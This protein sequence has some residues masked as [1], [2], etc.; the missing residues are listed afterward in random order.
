[1]KFSVKPTFN[2]SHLLPVLVLCLCLAVTYYLWSLAYQFSKQELQQQFDFR[3]NEIEILIKQR[4]RAYAEVLHGGRGLFIASDTVSRDE[5][6]VYINELDIEK[7]YPGI[8]GVGFSI[9]IPAG[10]KQQHLAAIRSEGFSDYNI[11]PEGVRELYSAI[12]YIE[13]FSDRNLRAFGFDMYSETVRRTAMDRAWRNNE[14]AFSG[15][16]TLVQESGKNVQAGF[17][18]YLPVYR[19][20]AD[21]S[22]LARRLANFRGW[23]YAP[24]RMDDFM[25][26]VLEK[27]SK[28]N[29]DVD[30]DIYDG[31]QPL[32]QALLYNRNNDS[33]TESQSVFSTRKQIAIAGNSWLLHIHSHA[34]F[35]KQ[36]DLRQAYLTA[37]V[38]IVIT[39]MLTTITWLLANS[40]RR[41]FALA[42]KIS[43]DLI[44]RE[45][46]YQQMFE[47]SSSIAVLIDLK[48]GNIIDAN[49][50]ASS[51]W[52]YSIEK[53][54]TMN[55]GEIDTR[56]ITEVLPLFELILSKSQ[57]V[58]AQHRL[59]DGQIKEVEIYANAIVYQGQMVIHS[60]VHDITT[61]KQQEE[62]IRRLSDSA[63]NKAKLEA[64]KANRVKSEFLANMSHEI[65]TPMNAITG[66][67]HLAL[68]TELTAKQRNYLNK[69]SYA[70]HSLLSIINDILDFSKIESG[71]LE[72]ET[73]PFS[74]DEVLRYIADIVEMNAKQKNIVV[75][76]LVNEG[77]PRWL[78]GDTLRLSQILINLASNAVKFTEQ[79]KI[80]ISVKPELRDAEAVVL[81]F[82][83]Q[84]S[85]IGMTST[86]IE[87]LFQPFSQADSSITRRYGGTGL[88]LTISKQL[89]EMMGGK[90]RVESEPGKGSTFIF[91]I[92]LGIAQKP[93]AS[94]KTG[95]SQQNTVEDFSC[96]TGR[97]IL[98][99]EDN[100][101]NRELATELLTNLGV[102][103][104]IAENGREAVKR[105]FKEPFDLV[106]MD[107]QM[108]EMDGLTA[109]RLI[110]ADVRF[111]RLPIIAMTANAMTGDRKNSLEAGMND[112]ISKPIMPEKLAAVLKFWL[113]NAIPEKLLKNPVPAQKTQQP[114][115]QLNS[116]IQLPDYLPSFNIAVA[117][118]RAAD[119]P[120]LLRK[121]LFMFNDEY[122]NLMP[123][124][125][126]YLQAGDYEEIRQKAHSLKGAAASLEATE[127]VA[128]AAALEK[129]CFNKEI[130]AIKVLVDELDKAL[131]A[132][133][134][135]IRSLKN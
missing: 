108:P 107:I 49:P 51:F 39:L 58:Y 99:V 13:P 18:M 79:G 6:K 89:V 10:K 62:E 105:V 97:K 71:R 112:H 57:H 122:Q 55:I 78:I 84:D 68:K 38:G 114:P 126:K 87:K 61:R 98:L 24:F 17:L 94:H 9:L 67:L 25:Q 48:N 50:A 12:I 91:T 109:T 115:P 36:I 106:F 14:I 86:Q 29:P 113:T 131:T 90:I 133:L 37:G 27:E 64:E 59:S 46:R 81:R 60:I 1:M 70:A 11:R 26:A 22:T 74:L 31:K 103:V 130:T 8:Q 3:A 92:K 120:E 96:L 93:V 123:E 41:A 69:I 128:V 129:A 73:A 40:R 28:I 132:A 21:I 127:V 118:Q 42:Q 125:K 117:L 66:M 102:V 15:K 119:S 110:R 111:S 16:V 23:I 43:A 80:I 95:Q 4:L 85:G 32:F 135:A 116:G 33:L 34:D 101:L 121:L 5:F 65:R 20:G 2:L 83:V 100:N 54:R 56:P 53:L 7:F 63:L 47:G 35:E 72:L 19:K 134:Q 75:A 82:S 104:E 45:T 76:T 124:F 88:G 30:L 52:G 77:T 44:E